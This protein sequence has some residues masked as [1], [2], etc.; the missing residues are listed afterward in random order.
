MECAEEGRM[1]MHCGEQC[2]VLMRWT[3]R[4]KVTTRV[5]LCQEQ[6]EEEEEGIKEEGACFLRVCL[7]MRC[8]GEKYCVADAEKV[9]TE[10]G[11]L[12]GGPHFHFPLG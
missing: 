7:T 3:S 10:T 9:K 11:L 2:L 8:F 6:G 4:K 12:G 1:M 5:C